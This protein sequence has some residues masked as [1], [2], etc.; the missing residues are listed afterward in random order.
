MESLFLCGKS[1]KHGRFS[2][3]HNVPNA[4][5]VLT[6]FPY[7]NV[8]ICSSCPG[9]TSK[10]RTLKI[11]AELPQSFLHTCPFRACRSLH[12]C[13]NRPI[14][15]GM[16]CLSEARTRFLT[17]IPKAENRDIA[18][19]C[20]VTLCLPTYKGEHSRRNDVGH[21]VSVCRCARVICH[22]L[23][24]YGL[25]MTSLHY[26]VTCQHLQHMNVWHL[27]A[28]TVQLTQDELVQ[29]CRC[30]DNAQRIRICSQLITLG[31]TQ[32]IGRC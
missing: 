14:K 32:N 29:V 2:K 31:T 6:S 22:L 11:G 27:P 4:P 18:N 1:N 28:C 16:E 9:L 25:H 7:A 30:S 3:F 23:T 19:P 21:V 8:G 26:G 20:R 10:I 12:S 5:L 15:F 17:L 24:H 13:S